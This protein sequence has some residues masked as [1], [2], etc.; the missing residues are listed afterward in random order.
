MQ[1]W[2]W[3]RR[4]H[5]HWRRLFLRRRL[6][7]RLSLMTRTLM[8]SFALSMARSVIC[9]DVCSSNDVFALFSPSS[10]YISKTFVAKGRRSPVQIDLFGYLAL[11]THPKFFFVTY[12][13]SS[14]RRA[15]RLQWTQTRRFAWWRNFCYKRSLSSTRLKLQSLFA[16]RTPS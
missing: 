8:S 7:R 14:T 4:T 15:S 3:Q 13:F 10:S 6:N 12:I 2:L 16:V 1:A 11:D 9:L 5:R